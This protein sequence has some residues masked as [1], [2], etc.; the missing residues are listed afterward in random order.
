MLK[1]TKK[2]SRALAR[3]TDRSE[4]GEVSRCKDYRCRP[5]VRDCNPPLFTYVRVRESERGVRL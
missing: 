3:Q 5:L 2:K 1:A 4:T